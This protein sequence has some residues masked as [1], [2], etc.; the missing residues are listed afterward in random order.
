MIL[1]LSLSLFAC[2]DTT[3]IKTCELKQRPFTVTYSLHGYNDKIKTVYRTVIIDTR[4]FT[5]VSSLDDYVDELSD[6]DISGS[7]LY[8]YKVYSLS[9][10]D[11]YAVAET[12][13]YFT[14][15]GYE[16]Y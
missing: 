3:T 7:D 8:L 9:S 10:G 2:K 13:D 6:V 11:Y 12:L 4:I 15:L 14:A 1:G 5:D 16:C